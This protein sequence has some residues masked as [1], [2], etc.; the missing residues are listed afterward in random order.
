[1]NDPVPR[2]LGLAAAVFLFF[3]LTTSA[4]A[5]EITIF[6]MADG[7]YYHPAS[8]IHGTTEEEVLQ[9]LKTTSNSATL[10][11][12]PVI[13]TATSAVA[14][15]VKAPKV[16]Q[17]ADGTFYHP[18]SGLHAASANDLYIKLGLDPNNLIFEDTSDS[19]S[20]D[21]EQKPPMI[22]AV[23]RAQASLQKQIDEDEAKLSAPEIV[24]S[25]ATWRDVTLAVWNKRTEEITFL[26]G[27]KN[28]TQLQ[29]EQ[30][31]DVKVARTNYVNSEYV[32]GDKDTLVVA[33][34]YPIL[35]K[36]A[37]SKYEVHDVVYSP[38][39]KD[40]YVPEVIQ[41][42]ENYINDVVDQ[43]FQ[44]MRDK[45]VPSRA[46][47][48]KLM[49]DVVDKDLLKTLI[50]IEHSDITSL[51]R[52]P[53]DAVNRVLATFGLNK[54]STYNYAKS[55]A[56]ALGIAQFMPSTY[57]SFVRRTQLALTPDFEA[58]MFDHENAVRAQAAYLDDALASLPSVA[59]E[60]G[61]GD[62]K[63]KEYLAASYNGGYAKVK[64][65]M[66]IWDEQIS[67]ELAPYEIKSR[68]RL[69]A[70]TIQYVK[71]LRYALPQIMGM[72]PQTQTI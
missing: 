57:T 32:L 36:I 70:E 46:Y 33:V 65:A 11:S 48:G 5:A 71:K 72:N 45:Q 43:A 27:K 9:Q 66:Q 22:A 8:G 16:F 44:V 1:M 31:A 64:T 60:I 3:A 61:M 50:I 52:N 56:G 7:S 4:H 28:G 38:F 24:T 15:R 63:V 62:A 2:S 51:S 34:R 10:V 17:M 25:D 30:D 42:G 6:H 18:G 40:L 47:P 19:L 37:T 21:V 53:E 54:G 12:A 39:S 58:G 26:K 69:H 49:A 59:R 41:E 55:G 14:S 20:A 29:L 23:E 13:P 35:K 67:G 68:S